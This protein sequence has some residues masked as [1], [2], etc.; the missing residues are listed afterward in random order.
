MASLS[1]HTGTLGRRLAA[2]LLRRTTFNIS[3]ARIDQ[4][5]NM[6]ANDAVNALLAAPPSPSM[7]EPLD[8]ET[9]DHFINL[10]TYDENNNS[11]MSRLRDYII[12]W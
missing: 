6:T 9:G 12:G 1:Q 10:G 7:P 3:K 2:H 5:S 11:D 4:F 8:P